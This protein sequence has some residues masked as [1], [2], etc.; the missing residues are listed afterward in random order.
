MSDGV[1]GLFGRRKLGE[2]EWNARNILRICLSFLHSLVWEFKQQRME[3]SFTC[4]EAKYEGIKQ[5]GENTHSSHFSPKLNF[6]LSQNLKELEG[7]LIS[8]FTLIQFHS[9]IIYLFNYIQFRYKLSNKVNQ[10]LATAKETQKKTFGGNN[11]FLFFVLGSSTTFFTRKNYRNPFLNLFLDILNIQKLQSLPTFKYN[12]K[13][14]KKFINH[15]VDVTPIMSS[16]L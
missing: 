15:I 3:K 1:K 7:T 8:L 10:A 11:Q 5:L 14:I 9:F 16:H 12:T 4:L 13:I 2:K 6:Y